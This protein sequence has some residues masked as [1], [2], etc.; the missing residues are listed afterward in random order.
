MFC[1]DSS[2]CCF[3]LQ[4]LV[5]SHGHQDSDLPGAEWDDSP[6][7]V[8]DVPLATGMRRRQVRRLRALCF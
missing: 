6:A 3:F 8:P 1:S 2:S 7:G 5:P 4:E